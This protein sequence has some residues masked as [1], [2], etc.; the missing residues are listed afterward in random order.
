MSLH[1]D[2]VFKIA[3]FVEH[4]RSYQPANFHWPSFSGSNSMRGGG[5]H[6]PPPPPRFTRSQKAQSLKR[7]RPRAQSMFYQ[8]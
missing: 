5:K 6:F 4:N 8:N 2:L 1:N 3:H 7:L